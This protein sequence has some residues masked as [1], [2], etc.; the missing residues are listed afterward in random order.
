M[1]V[2]LARYQSANDSILMASLDVTNLLRMVNIK[3]N[4]VSWLWSRRKIASML[5]SSHMNFNGISMLADPGGVSVYRSL[6][7]CKRAHSCRYRV[8][9]E[10]QLDKAMFRPCRRIFVIKPPLKLG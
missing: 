5:L 7:F 1:S 10:V 2:R 3:A 8:D 6:E 4:E 9:E